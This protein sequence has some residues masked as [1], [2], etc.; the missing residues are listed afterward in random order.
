MKHLKT[1]EKYNLI[2]GGKADELS[3]EEIAK[4]FSV[5]KSKIEDQLKKGIKVESE[6]TQDKKKQREI[7]MDHLSEIPDYYDRLLD[8]ENKAESK[9][10]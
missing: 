7:A 9:Y 5:P 8:M 10:K 4:K 6:H 2:K 3:V 1:F